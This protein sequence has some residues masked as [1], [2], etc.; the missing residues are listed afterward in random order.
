MV[1]RL[2]AAVSTFGAA[3]LLAVTAGVNPSAADPPSPPAES[4][5]RTELA[6][7]QVKA[8]HSMSGYS[9]DRFPHWA[10]QYGS[11]NTR[12]V[13]LQRDGQDV[14]TNDRCAAVSGR[15]YSVYDPVWVDAAEDVD[16][17]HFVPL[18]NAW[19]SG[20][21]AWTTAKRQR[22]ANDLE[23]Q[24]LIAV[25]DTTNQAKGD[26]SPDQWKPPNTGYWCTYAKSW[27]HVKHV[28]RLSITSAEKSALT[29]M[30]DRCSPAKRAVAGS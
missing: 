3:V 12:E 30:L 9:R 17:D 24:Q 18:A 25:R 1:R 4:V 11:C 13:V 16:I 5:V 22:F 19:R 21:Y 26:Q 20:A 27:T 8:P 29:A 6:S 14:Q 23:S 10:A 7:L 2:S 28:W 15:W